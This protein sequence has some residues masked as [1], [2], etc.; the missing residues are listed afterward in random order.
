MRDLIRRPLEIDIEISCD[1]SPVD[2]S[3]VDDV[4]DR[5]RHQCVVGARDLPA[6][7]EQQRRLEAV[8]LRELSMR[9]RTAWID[10]EHLDPGGDV[11]VVVITCSAELL[12]AA[13]RV[14]CGI[15]HQNDG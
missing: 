14:V 6:L 1:S 13:R 3:A 4:D 12:R 11:L 10:S 8:A 15:E 2:D 5:D 7:V 9:R